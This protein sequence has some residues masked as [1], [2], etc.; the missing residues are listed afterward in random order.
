MRVLGTGASGFL[1]RHVSRALLEA[2]DEVRGLARPGGG[3]LEPGVERAEVAGLDD[4][5]AVARAVAGVD[6]VVHLAA[7]VHLMRDTAADPAAE[8]RR[9]N[10][11]GTRLVLEEAIRAGA[12]RFLLASSV[13]AIGEGGDVPYT[14]ETP[15]APADPYGVSKLEAERVVREVADAAGVHAPVL[16]LPLVYGPGVRANFLRLMEMVDRGI[17]LPFGAVRNRRSLA[18]AGNVAA[19]AR[20]ALLAPA[21]ARE[22]FLVS[23]GEDLSTPQLV[24]A[25]AAALD[26]PARLVP[27]SPALFR[28]AGRAGD[29]LSTLVPFPLTTASVHRLLGSLAVDS[30]KLRRVA[31]FT[32]PYTVAQGLAETARWFR[33]RPAGAA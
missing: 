18:Y 27:V 32:P 6:A 19:A 15:P 21:A 20:A 1:G 17:P 13:K 28:A 3:P 29:A 25:L 30:S 26:R 11:E 12:G 31:G 14:E 4:R 7:R 23:D 9:V 22:T 8:F 2:G 24:R 10:V 33:S 5:A 16:R